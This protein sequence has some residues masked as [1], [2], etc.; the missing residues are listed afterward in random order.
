MLL[1]PVI[2]QPGAKLALLDCAWVREK[3]GARQSEKKGGREESDVGVCVYVSR[4]WGCDTKLPLNQAAVGCRTDTIFNEIITWLWFN[5]TF[6]DIHVAVKCSF[7]LIFYCKLNIKVKSQPKPCVG[8]L[9]DISEGFLWWI[10]RRVLWRQ[11]NL[12]L[13]VE[14]VHVFVLHE[15]FED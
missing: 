7:F 10:Q 3:G 15:A 11:N 14:I 2:S 12:L 6:Q 13:I 5:V 9:C 1:L 4:A 8:F